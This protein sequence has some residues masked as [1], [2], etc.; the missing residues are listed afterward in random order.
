MD[1]LD[2]FSISLQQLNLGIHE[3]DYQIE[4]T[5]FQQFEGSL[6]QQAMIDL[7]VIFEKRAQMY[8]ID[9]I[10]QGKVNSTCDRCL[11]AINLPIEG[12]NR[13]YVK[14]DDDEENADIDVI[15][16]QEGM[17]DF[18][19]AQYIYEFINL[20]LPIVKT[21]DCEDDENPPCDLDMLDKLYPEDEED[22]NDDKTGNPLW[23]QLKQIEDRL[24]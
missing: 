23:D 19:L 17:Q 5:F 7:K 20:S 2:N 22:I 4:N 8:I 6:I 9:F 11:T 21:Y 24:K 12:D 13:L 14:F 3:F 16:I 18:N 15:F 10:F 1:N